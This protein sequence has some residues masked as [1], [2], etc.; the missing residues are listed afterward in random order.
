MS[1]KFSILFLLSFF[2]TFLFSQD[3]AYARKVVDTL[4]SEFFCGRGAVEEGELKAAKY[5]E[6][7]FRYQGLKK[8][9]STY[10]Q[11]FNFSINSF[12]GQLAV[13]FDDSKLEPGVDFLVNPNSCQL[14]GTFK[15]VWYNQE[16]VPTKSQLKKLVMI[17]FFKDK[18]IIID[19]VEK[20]N[21][22]YSSLRENLLSAAGIIVV[23]ES[24]LTH[25]LST[26]FNDFVVLTVKRESLDQ[27]FRSITLS[28]DQ[29]FI[30]NYQSQNVIGYVEG[31]VY[32]D[33]F[34]LLTAHY[35]HLGKM[36]NEV[37][38]PGAND[39]ASGIAMLLNLIYHYT[40]KEP[41]TK[42]MV[43]I[44]F[45]AEEAGLIGS[46]YFVEHP[47]IALDKI[48][49]VCNMDLMGTG[50]EGVMVVN[51]SVYPNHYKLLTS[52][53]ERGDYVPI[54]KKRGKAQNSDHYW[55]SEKGVPA[56]FM[57]TMGGIKAYH[58]IE[59]VSKTLPLTEFED[60]FRLIRDF[61]DEL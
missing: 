53:N 23:E 57:Y 47:A 12:P 20:E 6:K 10:F 30:R 59:D 2:S 43:F 42:T 45:G 50:S 18:F 40:H 61:I 55:F 58:D 27:G 28:I 16:N 36:G 34:V 29:K 26:T 24:K 39:N 1:T 25:S 38:F 52:V 4:T 11:P 13:S 51:G 31:T 17:D 60:C 37:Y 14:R 46:K 7:E 35:D 19:G 15:L 3:I 56:F 9:D 48:N 33:S 22:V 44:A 54:I 5:L 8:F 41:P 21:E 49:F 32:P